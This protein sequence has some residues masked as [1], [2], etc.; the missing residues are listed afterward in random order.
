[1]N[2]T[3]II[4]VNCYIWFDVNIFILFYNKSIFWREI[5]ILYD[6]KILMFLSKNEVDM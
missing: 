5:N 3:I 6:I 4:K 2:I 1:M